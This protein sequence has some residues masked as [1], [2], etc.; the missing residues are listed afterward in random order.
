VIRTVCGPV[1]SSYIHFYDKGWNKLK[2]DLPK[3][4]N[5][6]WIKN[7]DEIV[8]GVNVADMFPASFIELRFDTKNNGIEVRNNSAEYLSG[9]D[10]KVIEP[11]MKKDIVKLKWNNGTWE[12]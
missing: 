3:L 8:N 7:P 11:L 5:R 1:C 6:D 4:T 10:K 9:E 12:R 2:M